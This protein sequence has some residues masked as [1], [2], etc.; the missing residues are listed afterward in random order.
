M[1][2]CV[3]IMYVCIYIYIHTYALSTGGGRQPEHP[4]RAPGVRPLVL[5]ARV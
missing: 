4:A 3:Y 1:Y 5:G 2:V